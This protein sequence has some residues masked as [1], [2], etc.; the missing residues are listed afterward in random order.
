M[1]FVYLC[2]QESAGVNHIQEVSEPTKKCVLKE[3]E[4][5]KY[6]SHIEQKWK[7]LISNIYFSSKLISE[8]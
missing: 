3:K 5:H 8:A 2:H 6:K 4:K 7:H 1:H